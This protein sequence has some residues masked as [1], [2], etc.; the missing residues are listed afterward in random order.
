MFI[1]QITII[2]ILSILLPFL[3]SCDKEINFPPEVK[4]KLSALQSNSIKLISA[5]SG[6]TLVLQTSP[7]IFD[8][9]EEGKLKNL[10]ERIIILSKFKDRLTILLEL[11]MNLGNDFTFKF[12]SLTDYGDGIE[13]AEYRASRNFNTDE[14]IGQF[15]EE[16]VLSSQVFTGLLVLRKQDV[17]GSFFDLLVYSP[18]VGL[19]KYNY[20]G[21]YFNR[22]FECE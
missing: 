9:V 17:S 1:K 11:K 21:E 16:L 6:D 8:Y 3:S 18:M 15:N 22:C 7:F 14:F 4:I 2:S 13:S 5:Q 20:L 10:F 12:S 19:I